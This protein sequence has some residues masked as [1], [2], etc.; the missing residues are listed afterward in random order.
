MAHRSEDLRTSRLKREYERLQQSFRSHKQIRCAVI[1]GT[2]PD[3]YRIE[4]F[5][6]GI[7]RQGTQLIE[8]DHHVMEVSL[9]VEYPRMP[10]ACKMLSPVFHPNIDPFTVCISDFHSPQETLVDIII[11][12]GQMIAY[13]KHNVKSPLNGEA[14]AWCQQ[15]L[16][17]L[18]VDRTDLIPNGDGPTTIGG[19]IRIDS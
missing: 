15:N 14:A 19:R 4:Y 1:G 7:E 12:V 17:L 16:H 6:K 2:P 8:R 10:A 5:I 9:P 18:P 13:Q 3:R 11:R